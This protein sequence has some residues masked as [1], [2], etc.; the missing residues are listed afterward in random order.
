MATVLGR[1]PGEWSRAFVLIHPAKKVKDQ[2][3]KGFQLF[4]F[5]KKATGFY[6]WKPIAFVIP[7][8]SALCNK[9]ICS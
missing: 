5:S 4:F 7:V 3:H 2:Y 9:L 1:H 6:K 8:T